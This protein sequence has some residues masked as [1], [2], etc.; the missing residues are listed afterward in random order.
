VV[1]RRLLGATGLEVSELGFG[2]S[3]FWAKAAFPEAR[4]VALLHRAIEG[5]VRFFDTGPSYAGG[6]A[7]RR[8]A[9]ALAA[10]PRESLV[11]ATKA[12][13]WP[14]GR[15]FERD[16][17][18]D[19]VRL[20]LSGSLERLGVERVD[21]LHLHGPRPEHLTDELLRCLEDLVRE[22]RV[23]ACG[24]NGFGDELERIVLENDV[25]ATMMFDY[26]LLRV[27]RQPIIDRL[28]GAGKGF[29][30]ATPLAQ[31][32]FSNKLFKPRRSADL[33][34]L[35]RALRKHRK[36]V[37]RGFDF[38]F[39]NHVPGWT[40]GEVAIAYALANPHVSVAIFGT[41]SRERLEENLN[42]AE[43]SLPPEIHRR[44]ES[45]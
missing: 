24:V 18:P 4:A 38:R 17:S 31:A 26:N 41:T 14:R 2:C 13:T 12:G 3:S 15:S 43:R 25:L 22:G 21:L 34:Y 10:H 28:A 44:I 23:G 1:S 11:V 6:V 40:G 45:I 42:A 36:L 20:G 7:E 19:A 32:F 30:A 9:I 27:D 16:F 29:L 35:A 33:W 5:G 39:V 8:L 37:R